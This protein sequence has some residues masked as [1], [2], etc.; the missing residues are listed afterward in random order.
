MIKY[1]II[2]QS[3]SDENHQNINQIKFIKRD[4]DTQI[5]LLHFIAHFQV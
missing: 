2:T 1:Y 5:L 4:L 3:Y